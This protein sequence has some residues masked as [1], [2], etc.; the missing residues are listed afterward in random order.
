MKKKIFPLTSQ[1]DMEKL[2][3]M[4]STYYYLIW[5]SDAPIIKKEITFSK[6]KAE[7]HYYM[8]LNH[9]IDMFNNA[10]T[11]KEKKEASDA[12]L[13]LHIVPLRIH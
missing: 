10:K 9:T 12:F 6:E 4:E 8:L 11:L 1:K 13:G 5:L 2:M 7:K 3:L